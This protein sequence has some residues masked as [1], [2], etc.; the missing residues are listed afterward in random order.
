MK[1]LSLIAALLLAGCGNGDHGPLSEQG[2]IAPAPLLDAFFAQVQ[3]VV[4]ARPDA[5]EPA[6][7]DASAGTAPENSEPVSL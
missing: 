2:L 3:T 4:A 5:S 1:K 7:I 6:S